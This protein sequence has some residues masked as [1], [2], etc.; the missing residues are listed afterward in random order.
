MK[1]VLVIEDNK[2]ILENVAELLELSN[3]E[4]CTAINGRIGIEQAL[5]QKPDLIVCDI[6]MPKLDGYAVL[7]MVQRNS[8]LQDSLL[9]FNRTPREK[10][11]AQGHVVRGR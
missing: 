2:E 9:F 10:R 8:D 3:Y 1:K 6:M 7:H 4:V 11:N 5:L